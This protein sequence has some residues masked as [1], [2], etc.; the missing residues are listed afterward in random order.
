MRALTGAT[1][2][3][4]AFSSHVV[5]VRYPAPIAIP[6]QRFCGDP[7][8]TSRLLALISVVESTL[9]YLVTL[10]ISDLLSSRADQEGPLLPDHAAFDPLRKGRPPQLG[11]W[12]GLLRATA[13][14]LADEPERSV[15]ELP[16]VCAGGGRLDQDLFGW[17][18]ARRNE[19]I[20][21]TQGIQLS[22]EEAGDLLAELRPRLE[23]ALLAVEFV[24]RYPLGFLAQSESY[25]DRYYLH[26]CM[27]PRIEEQ[28]Y[29]FQSSALLEPEVPFVAVPGRQRL[30]Y[31]WPLLAQRLA[32]QS[33][34]H[35]LYRFEQLAPRGAFLSC[36]PAP[37]SR[38]GP[39]S[40]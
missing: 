15:E 36:R 28:G 26:G 13:K 19:W 32:H 30:L 10:G 37:A 6:Y 31:L 8:K 40:R 33:Q 35:T 20:H 3:S 18:V 12:L 24:R 5:I 38:W 34:R 2:D 29:A 14:V 1:S 22:D 9:R 16:H 11:S 21:P 7:G 27:G 4:T 39:W 25:P 23:E 17:L